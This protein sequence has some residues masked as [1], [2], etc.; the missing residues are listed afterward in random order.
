MI[1]AEHPRYRA[2]DVPDEIVVRRRALVSYNAAMIRHVAIVGAGF[3]GTLVAINLLRHDGPRVT[4]IERAPVAGQGLAY[5]AA[6]PG[7][8]LNVRA[9][10]MS[11][12][13]DDPDH[14]V[15]WLDTNGMTRAADQFVERRTYGRYLRDSL[16]KAINRAGSR[17]TLIKDDAIDI[18][19]AEGVTVCLRD[20]KVTADAAVLAVG[21]LPPHAPRGLDPKRLSSRRWKGDPWAP[22]VAD[23]LDDTDTV[24]VLGTGLTMV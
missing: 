15:R 21:N 3:S 16:T 7:H 24:L 18:D 5:G 13:P 19:Q 9:S 12:F 20:S 2:S 23:G 4:L 11:A 10:N 14:F 22:G 8:L 17:L 6:H 1:E